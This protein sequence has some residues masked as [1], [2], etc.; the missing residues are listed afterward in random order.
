MLSFLQI[1]NLLQLL[2]S[3][4]MFPVYFSSFLLTVYRFLNAIG[5]F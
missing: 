3:I 2:N 1:L 5:L 4:V